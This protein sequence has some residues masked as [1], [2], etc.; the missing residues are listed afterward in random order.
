MLVT[1][2]M[3][4]L[5]PSF[6]RAAAFL[7]GDM[8]PW[9]VVCAA[10]DANADPAAAPADARHLLE[11]C[12]LCVLQADGWGLPPEVAQ[13]DQP[14]AAAAHGV[15]SL[16]LRAPHPLQAWSSAQPRAPPRPA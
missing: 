13:R 6:A 4:A 7:Q 11:H 15:P 12:P 2:V 8:A 3:A 16:F 14:I 1:L 10:P 9:S 5:V